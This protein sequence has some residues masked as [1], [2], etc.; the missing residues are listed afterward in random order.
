MVRP[1]LEDVHRGGDRFQHLFRFVGAIQP[2]E[3][4][5]LPVSG[6]DLHVGILRVL[7]AENIGVG[8][9]LELSLQ[10]VRKPE[11]VV[12]VR[13]QRAGR[14]VARIRLAVRLHFVRTVGHERRCFRQI[15]DRRIELADR[16]VAVTAMP[17]QPRVRRMSADGGGVDGDGVPEPREVGGA[18]PEPDRRVDARR[19]LVELRLRRGE[20]RFEPGPRLGRW[21]CGE[22]RLSQQRRRFGSR[23]FLGGGQRENQ[24]AGNGDVRHGRSIQ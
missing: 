13:F 4:H 6:R 14:N 1:V 9:T 7:H 5:V 8:G 11:V 3:R 15:C 17:I 16:D 24:R 19:V 10:V 23:R 22:E 2:P 18:P 12:D 20:V 21:W